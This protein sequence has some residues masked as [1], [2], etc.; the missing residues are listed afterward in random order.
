MTG[1]M[2]IDDGYIGEL[3]QEEDP[4]KAELDGQHESLAIS[5]PPE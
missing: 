1:I 3:K 2:E 4:S 5:A